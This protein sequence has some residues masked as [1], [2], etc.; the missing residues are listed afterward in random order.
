MDN[1]VSNMLSSQASESV[2][3][4]TD[5]QLLALKQRFSKS[6]SP[7]KVSFR[8]LC[9][10]WPWAKRSDVYT[11]LTHRYPAKLLAYIP[12]FFLSGSFAEPNDVVLDPFAG[13]GTVLLESITHPYFPRLAYGVEINPLARLIAKV[14]TTPID[15]EILRVEATI[16][17]QEIKRFSR[18]PVIPDFP[19]R[20][21][22]FRPS[23]QRDLAIVRDCIERSNRRSP[24]V[25]DF[26]RVCLSSI[27]R[28]VSWADPKVAPP[29]K[30]AAGKFP[31]AQQEGI[32]EMIAR[33][34]R[35]NVFAYFRIA[36]AKNIMRMERLYVAL[37]ANRKEILASAEIIWDDARK[38]R[39]G[40]Y[41]ERG[42]LDQSSSTS[43]TSQVGLI[44]TSPPYINA[45]K[46]VR[47]TKFE[48]WWLGLETPD[49]II[50]LDKRF[51]GT[52][53]IGY[54]DYKELKLIGNKT[55]DRLL[56]KIYRKSSERA[57]VV[58]RYFCDMRE[59]IVGAHKL[60]K[61]GGR[62]V[63]VVGNNTITDYLVPS[64]EILTEL[65]QEEGRFAVEAILVDAI[66]SRGLITSRHET[67]GVIPE[68]WILVLQKRN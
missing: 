44:I 62:L 10:D 59:V 33:K 46:Y 65:A 41:I 26:F 5:E 27:I 8:D 67:A 52:E 49:T 31:A 42:E 60:L 7:Q 13:T 22:W 16:L 48:I 14:K 9:S 11:H 68:E 37:Y 29:V 43:L 66:R 15:P 63:I 19:N 58:S 18:I 3:A 40:C 32:E 64:R 39:K 28:D 56:K 21:F 34:A 51:I 50:D 20:D 54:D 35:A 23:V 1:K 38:I 53:R 24:D 57:G 6:G 12:I 55:A 47:T 30:L 2:K 17:F 25:R 61:P 4:W 45:Q 36:V